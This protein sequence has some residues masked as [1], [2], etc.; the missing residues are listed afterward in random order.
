MQLLIFASPDGDLELINT[1]MAKHPETTFAVNLG[2]MCLHSSSSKLQY[3]LRSKFRDQANQSIEW[4]LNNKQF[5]K[6]LINLYGAADDPFIPQEELKIG[7]LLPT[8]AKVED[9]ISHNSNYTKSKKIKCGFL[10]GY[11]N[12][13]SFKRSNTYRNKMSRERKSTMLCKDDLAVFENVDNLDYFFGYESPE[14][15]R[16]LETLLNRLGPKYAFF[17]HL[18]KWSEHKNHIH[19]G[20]LKEGYVILDTFNNE[21]KIHRR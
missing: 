19:V 11:F 5:N 14:V 13:K 7:Y 3:F 12:A 1:T 18:R 2:D 17:G 10:S 8:W 4:N 16:S 21:Y 6:L 20:P 15:C 9:F